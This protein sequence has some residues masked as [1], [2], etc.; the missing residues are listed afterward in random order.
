MVIKYNRADIDAI[1]RKMLMP[2]SVVVCPRCGK[3]LTYKSVGNSC[4]VKCPTA[5][6]IKGTS[7]GV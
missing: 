7:R 4:E 1:D 6:C 2:A 5:G 3:E